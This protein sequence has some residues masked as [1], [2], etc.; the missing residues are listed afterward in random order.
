MTLEQIKALPADRLHALTGLFPA[1]LAELLFQVLPELERRRALRTARP[2]RKRAPGGGRKR[3]L[4]ATQQVLMVLVYLRHNVSHEVVG[5]LFGVCAD[6]SEDL[7]HEIVPVLRDSCPSGRFDAEKRWK[8]SEASWE[9]RDVD[10]ILID[11]FETSVP[12]PSQEPQQKRR[13]SGKTKRHTLK[14]QVVTDTSGE[15][16]EVDAG[17]RGPAADKTIYQESGVAQR[18]PNA[19]KQADKG[20]HGAKDI[21][22]PHRKPKGGDLTPEQRAEN[23]EMAATR[24]RVEHA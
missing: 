15:I 20:Y 19:V 1:M 10:R 2:G 16:L 22:M 5:S 4:T 21:E 8:K 11:S 18:Y 7:F 24:V 6:V 3:R 14:T 13:Y 9:P 12:R 17:H 23:R